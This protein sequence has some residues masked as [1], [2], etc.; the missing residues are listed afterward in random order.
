MDLMKYYA[1]IFEKYPEFVTQE[2]MGEICGICKK[3][4][5][6][7][8]HSG[9]IPY[10]V[11]TNRLGRTHRIKLTDV[12][13]YLYEK[14]C[15]QE[16]DSP[17]IIEMKSFYEKEFAGFPDLLIVKDIEDMTGFSSTCICNWIGRKL[18]RTIPLKKGYGI[19]KCCFIDFLVS[20]YYRS[21]KN[22]TPLQKK[23]MKAFEE[24]WRKKGGE[25]THDP[26]RPV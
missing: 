20:P 6:T 15:R 19:P 4:A 25:T 14:E 18:F 17:Y 11:E 26:E 12:L 7:L 10:T 23:H 22:K 8:A 21:I 24:W 3:T 9:K 1:P 5:Y 13:L 16:P 2:Q